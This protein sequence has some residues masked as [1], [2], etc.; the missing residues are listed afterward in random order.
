MWRY[1][2]PSAS[3]CNS[4]PAYSPERLPQHGVDQ[5]GCPRPQRFDQLDHL[6]HNRVRRN[7]LQKQELI[8]PH[9][10]RHPQ[11]QRVVAQFILQQ[12]LQQELQSR[13]FQRRTPW[14]S[15]VSNAR[16][17][18]SNRWRRSVLSRRRSAYAR[19]RSIRSSSSQAIRRAEKPPV[20]S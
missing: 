4:L 13:R 8:D 18:S 17:R 15:S 11:R 10:K 3:G 16:S 20:H 9:G 1:P 7:P 2:R 6:M 12:P 14:S 19:S 5:P